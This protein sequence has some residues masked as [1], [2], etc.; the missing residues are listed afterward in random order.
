MASLSRPSSSWL[1]REAMGLARGY[2]CPWIF[3]GASHNTPGVLMRAELSQEGPS[4]SCTK[5]LGEMCFPT[6]QLSVVQS[7]HVLIVSRCGALQ[8]WVTC[9]KTQALVPPGCMTWAS[10][11]TSST[12]RV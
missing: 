8:E 11:L 1:T 12:S 2:G 5:H 4:N 3:S 9:G 7:P 6:L 10:H